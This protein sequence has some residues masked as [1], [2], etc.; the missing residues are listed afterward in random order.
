MD[1]RPKV[2]YLPDTMVSWPWPR[3]INPHYENFK[4]EVDASISD[5]KA[6]LSPES[7]VAFSECDTERLRI[8]FDLLNSILF[9]EEYTTVED[10]AV[11]K[12]IVDIV[13]DVLHNPHKIRP[14]G[15]CV[16]G[17]LVRQYWA[18]AI[19]S[20]SLSSQRHFLE[21]FTA[22]LQG[23]VGEALDRKQS[24]RRSFDD[25]L[26]LR[27]CTIGL[28]PCFFM[29]E[30][31]M[32]LPDEVFYHPAIMDLIECI[33]DLVLIDN[34]MISYNK[35]QAV[36]DEDHN[37]ISIIMLELGLDI[38]GAMAWAA[39]YHAKV[40]KRFIDGRANVPSWGPSIDVLVEEYLEGIAMCPRANHSWCYEVQRYFS[41][42]GLEIQQTGLVTLLPRHNREAVC[43]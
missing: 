31:G 36:G 42:R 4:A 13:I 28:K 35:E 20:A 32:D 27:R 23:V 6:Q 10:G 43:K 40:Q 29:C 8:S 21:A 9:L 11:I 2:I 25:Y 38:S 41:S 3:T 22:Y 30:M 19:Q 15:E 24:H 14:G 5:F 7:Q 34:D 37:M 26:K 12:E 39:R 1:T 18:R 17:E 33:T 16:L